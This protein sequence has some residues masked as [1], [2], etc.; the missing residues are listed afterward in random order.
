[1]ELGFISTL[2]TVTNNVRI[3]I[4]EVSFWVVPIT[5]T[6]VPQ[7]LT[8]CMEKHVQFKP[9]VLHI[10]MKHFASKATKIFTKRLY[11]DAKHLG[12]LCEVLPEYN[13]FIER[14]LPE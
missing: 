9:E 10:L 8:I 2:Y 3:K 4:I 12:G 14:K 1:M 11:G 5:N 6:L 7:N 13:C